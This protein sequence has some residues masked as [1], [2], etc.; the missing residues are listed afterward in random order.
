[1][2]KSP[3]S[4]ILIFL[5]MMTVLSCSAGSGKTA[6]KDI[7]TEQLLE[8]QQQGAIVIDVRTPEEWDATGIIPGAKKAMYFNQQMQPVEDEFL[9]EISAIT[10]NTNKPVVLYCRSGG[11]SG[12][13]AKLLAEQSELKNVYSLDGGIQ[14][15]LAEGKATE[16]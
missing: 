9:K 5:L 1:M 13:A 11:R 15:W 10:S 8:L 14:K 7:N 3:Q 4:I 2:K 12:K 16:K 6:I